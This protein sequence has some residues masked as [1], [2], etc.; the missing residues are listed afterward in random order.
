MPQYPNYSQ[1]INPYQ[2][3]TYPQFRHHPFATVSPEAAACSV[4]FMAPSKTFNIAGIVSSYAIVPD[5]ELR[6][7]FY[8]FLEAG[9]LN[10]GTIFAALSL[11]ACSLIHST[12]LVAPIFSPFNAVV[13]IQGI[14]PLKNSG[15]PLDGV[16][17]D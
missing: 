13:V 15:F 5:A 14:V 8:S 1:M 2:Q 17:P 9:A 10:A 12:A 4:T 3:M 16:P 6:E 11:I 7:K